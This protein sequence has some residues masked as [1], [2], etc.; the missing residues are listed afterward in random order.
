MRKSTLKRFYVDFSVNELDDDKRDTLIAGVAKVAPTSSIIQSTPALLASA[1]ALVTKGASYKTSRTTAAG[2]RKIADQDEAKALSDRD[3]V[4]AEL[5]SFV[6]IL[7]A[8]AKSPQD[9]KGAA[10]DER[11]PPAPPPPFGPPDSID[12]TFPKK[13]KGWFTT[14]PHGIKKRSVWVVQ[15]S[16]E[17]IGPATWTEAHGDGNSRKIVGASGTGVWVRY[18]MLRDGQQSA[19]STP[20]FVTFP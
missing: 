3:A 12:V 16:P 5:L 7:Q 19:W 15:T 4:D 18:A 1:G 6:G 17:A 11:P 8:N 10:F 20:V 2:S 9:F 14:R 13:E